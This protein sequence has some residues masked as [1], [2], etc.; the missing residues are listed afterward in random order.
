MS[1]D[2]DAMNAANNPA[3]TLDPDAVT[4]AIQI[5]VVAPTA[6]FG[7]LAFFGKVGKSQTISITFSEPVTDSDGAT[8]GVSTFITN[9]ATITDVSESDTDDQTTYTITFTPNTEGT[10]I[11]QDRRFFSF[12]LPANGVRDLA[13]L[14]GPARLVI[15]SGSAAA[16]QPPVAEAGDAPKVTTGATVTLDGSATDPDD[17]VA[18][19]TYA[20][21][22]T[23]GTLSGSAITLTDEDTA[24]AMVT[25]PDTAGTLEF[26]LTVTDP[27]GAS[28]ADTVTITVM[29]DTTPPTAFFGA[30][31]TESSVGVAQT[32]SLIFSENVTGLNETALDET[33]LSTSRGVIDIAVND[34]GA[35]P[36]RFYSITFTPNAETFTLILAAHSATT[37]DGITGPAE[38]VQLEGTAGADDTKPEVDFYFPDSHLTDNVIGA[39]QT[40]TFRFKEVVSGLEVGD[41]AASTGVTVNE[42]I[43][44]DNADWL[45]AF[46]PT[47][48]AFKLIL[49]ADAVTDAAGN[50]NVEAIESG[51]AQPVLAFVAGKEPAL[52]SSNAGSYAIDG[53]TLEL[54][55]SVNLP[56]DSESDPTVT[57][58]GQSVT[59]TGSGNDYTAT[60][61]VVAAQ[62]TALD[63]MVASYD[64]D[65]MAAAD[66]AANTFDPVATNSAIQIDVTAPVV[67]V[68]SEG[69][70]EATGPTTPL[71]ATDYGIATSTD[72]TITDNAPGTF[73]LGP[74]TIIWSA[75]DLAGNV[76]TADQTVTVQD[77]TKPVITVPG[78]ITKEATGP[79]TSVTVGQAT[80]TDAAADPVSITRTPEANEF[81]VG[82]H[83]ITWKADDGNGNIITAEQTITITDTTKP[84]IALLG[85]NPQIIAFGGD[86]TRLLATATDA[87]DDNNELTGRIDIDDASVD[88][89]VAGDYPVTYNVS[90]TATNAADTVTRTVTVQ[91][92]PV[93]A[94]QPP[95]A[96]AGSDKPA[97]TGTTVMLD[98]SASDD[99][100]G[101]IQSYVWEHTSTGGTTLT[102]IIVANGETSTFTAPDVAAILTFTLTVTDNDGASN[103]NTDTDTNTAT[104]T[105]TAPDQSSDADLSAL[106]ITDNT[107]ATVDLNQA[108]NAAVQMGY[109]ADVANDVTSVTL[110]PTVNAAATVTVADETVARDATSDPITLT[111]G[112]TAIDIVVTA[113][114][115]SAT[116]KT[117]TVTITR[118]ANTAPSIDPGNETPM[119]DENTT[120][121][122]DYDADDDEGNTIAWTL[123]GTDAGLFMISA[124]GEL[125]FKT[126]PDYEDARGITYSVIVHATE[127][128]GVPSNLTDELAVTITVV[129]QD[130]DGAIDSIGGTAQVG[131]TL[132]AGDVTDQDASSTPATVTNWE[133]QNAATNATVAEGL[134][135]TYT[136]VAG[137]LGRTIQVVATYTD[138]FGVKTLISAATVAVVAA[139]VILSADAD[140]SGLTISAGTLPTLP[141]PPQVTPSAWV[142][143]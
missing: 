49:A 9:G 35:N 64:I 83:T 45:I 56:L 62:V 84:V 103:I 55:F 85:A 74:T 134:D 20:W 60:Y 30:L 130:D 69:P 42:V 123:T 117:Y 135:N 105:V 36:T 102:P 21:T 57:I 131:K 8:L 82:T 52:T 128:N 25:A 132:T 31:N 44:I 43:L 115:I 106:T 70:F 92:A 7:T 141:Q 2:I 38:A 51:S 101:T 47:A 133:W 108:F 53:D 23:G 46:T 113:E 58:A 22:Q 26:T 136:L 28:H 16:N 79:T 89:A 27:A 15:A 119:V 78:N 80:A 96:N 48:T 111:V 87:V 10:L 114:D 50:G 18:D 99:P 138:S 13:G 68:P 112:E 59:A 126:A 121:V 90:D 143:M 67:S 129:N 73:P 118:A 77:T 142:M 109:T 39:R 125:A 29:V 127:T 12:A 122:A 97:T 41:Y 3:N 17:N 1:Y 81:A 139:D 116:P 63:G 6:A 34:F 54:T 33:A 40:V 137:D 94:N 32:T 107:G 91:A 88:T 93:V 19:L 100:D 110:R 4:S 72:G 24:K 37:T 65:A 86:Y 71:S 124:D 11:G 98:G 120:I 14:T 76:G 61:T 66:N 75:T 104:I 5:D 140:L 95:V